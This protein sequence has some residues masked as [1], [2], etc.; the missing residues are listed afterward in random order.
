MSRQQTQIR[1]GYLQTL[2][3]IL[4]DC[5]ILNGLIQEVNDRQDKTL[6][7]RHVEGLVRRLW[8]W[9]FEEKRGEAN[10][11]ILTN[12]PETRTTQSKTLEH[13]GTIAVDTTGVCRIWW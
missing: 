5:A 1:T 2:L 4:L 10:P 3:I 12:L 11:A 7:G 13:A 9:E 6:L 8:Q